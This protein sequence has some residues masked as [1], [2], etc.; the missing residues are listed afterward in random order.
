MPQLTVAV[1]AIPTNAPGKTEYE[2]KEV[3]PFEDKIVEQIE[4]T[5][6]QK[7]AGVNWP[8]WSDEVCATVFWYLKKKKG[9]SE[10]QALRIRRKKKLTV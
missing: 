8:G 5:F 6:P 3:K 2:P 10:D 9:M 1:N 7:L 4:G